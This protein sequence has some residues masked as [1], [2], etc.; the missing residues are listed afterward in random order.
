MAKNIMSVFGVQP[1]R[2][3]GASILELIGRGSVGASVL[4][5]PAHLRARS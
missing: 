1:G 5:H 3:A 2:A 4:A